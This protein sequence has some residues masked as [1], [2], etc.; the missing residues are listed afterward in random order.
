VVREVPICG[1]V[2]QGMRWLARADGG[3]SGNRTPSCSGLSQPSLALLTHRQ[4]WTRQPGSQSMS[5]WLASRVRRLEKVGLGD[6]VGVAGRP[7]DQFD[8]ITVGV[9]DPAGPRSVRVA[10]VGRRI[11]RNTLNGKIGEGCIQ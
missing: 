9:G 10:R 11:G 2:A 3:M 4:G 1:V 8:S 7:L 5:D 6:A